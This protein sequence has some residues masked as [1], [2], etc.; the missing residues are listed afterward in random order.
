[1]KELTLKRARELIDYNPRS[2]V[3]R[4]K[5]R[6]IGRRL[7]KP[8]GS[9]GPNDSRVVNIDGQ[10]YYLHHIA[11]LLDKGKWPFYGVEHVN[12]VNSD[13]RIVN[14]RELR[15]STPM[16]KKKR[17]AKHEI[18]RLVG[19]SWCADRGK[20]RSQIFDHGKNLYIGMFDTEREA[21]EA[22]NKAK[23]RQ[24]R[25]GTARLELR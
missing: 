3:M 19:A 10:R 21:H 7:D 1:M 11:W 20:W 15:L 2:G 22:Y 18:K 16:P 4:W 17:A 25:Y 13:N 8:I 12:G 23:N 6:G 24:R 5:Q 9:V 14:L